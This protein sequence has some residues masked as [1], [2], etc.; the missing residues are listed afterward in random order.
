MLP[1]GTVPNLM[2]PGLEVS[3]GA[4]SSVKSNSAMY[5]VNGLGGSKGWFNLSYH[6]Q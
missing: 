2:E 5:V 3:D 1:T 4:P 6:F